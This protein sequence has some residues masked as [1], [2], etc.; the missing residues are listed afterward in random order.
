[1]S[2]WSDKF[3]SARAKDLTGCFRFLK[4]VSNLSKL[5]LEDFAQQEDRSLE[6]LEFLQQHY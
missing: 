4:D 6:W 2:R 1:M 3:G 5:V